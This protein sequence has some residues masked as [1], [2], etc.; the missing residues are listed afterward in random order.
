MIKW[1]EKS[2]RQNTH[3]IECLCIPLVY[4][5]FKTMTTESY[6]DILAEMESTFK[7]FITRCLYIRKNGEI[8]NTYNQRQLQSSMGIG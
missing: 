2:V 7:E 5:V 6:N 4:Y 3:K 8:M 1:L